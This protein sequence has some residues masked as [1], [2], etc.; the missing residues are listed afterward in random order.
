MLESVDRMRGDD[1]LNRPVDYNVL[2]VRNRPTI[3]D[4][5]RLCGVTPA[6][7]SRVLNRKKHFSTSQAVREKIFDTARKL[8]YV[9]DLAARNLNRRSTRIIGIFSAPHTSFTWGINQSLLEGAAGVLHAEGYDVFFEVSS[10]LKVDHALPF[11]KFDGA[12][13]FQSPK[14]EIIGELDNRRVP[15]VCVNER[16]G[17]PVAN[18]LADDVMGVKLVVR[19]LAEL[20]HRRVAYAN[21][22]SQYH[23]HY[24]VVER[25]E[26]L[27]EETRNAGGEVVP[28]HDAPFDDAEQFLRRSVIEG[29]ATAV[30]TYDHTIAV[31]VLGAAVRLGLRVPQDFSVVCFNDEFPTSAIAPS[32]TAVA[33]WG[34][35]M[36]RIGA[37]TLLKNLATGQVPPTRVIRVPETLH[38]RESTGPAP[39]RP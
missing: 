15:Y 24:S 7:V 3:A 32:L 37:E 12:V 14:R 11:W 22:R 13:L 23:P 33:V 29:S 17:S 35:E 26:T 19:H 9:P 30:V 8:G 6:T 20:G 27:L 25:H 28:G 39:H 10:P 38:V 21:A 18:V 34:K 16:L 2:I 5:A 36:G 31:T 1:E 4:V